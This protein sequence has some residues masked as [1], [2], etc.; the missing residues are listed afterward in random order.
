MASDVPITISEKA[1]D[2]INEQG[3]TLFVSLFH[4]NASCCTGGITELVL[5]TKRP[6]G[7]NKF[8]KIQHKE[9][10][11]LLEPNLPLKEKGLQIHLS[12]FGWIKR[13]Q[14]SGL[15]RF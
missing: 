5:S 10:E 7:S 11:L 12:S 14:A 8:Q 4:G 13:L 2:Y 15:Q 1:Y 3:G 6:S 9:I